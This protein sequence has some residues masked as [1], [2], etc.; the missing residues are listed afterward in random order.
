VPNM[1][2]LHTGDGVTVRATLDGVDLD[3]LCDVLAAAGRQVA[4][5]E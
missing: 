4:L 5:H 2:E 1:V 3:V